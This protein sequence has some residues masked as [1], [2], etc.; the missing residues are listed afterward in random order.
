MKKVLIALALVVATLCAALAGYA[1][2][3]RAPFGVWAVAFVLSFCWTA[4]FA[5]DALSRVPGPRRV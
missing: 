2:G 1:L 4:A 3:A 5:L